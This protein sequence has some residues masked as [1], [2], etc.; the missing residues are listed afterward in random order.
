ML[1]DGKK[2]IWK[3]TYD[4][5]PLQQPG[6]QYVALAKE[7]FGEGAE[8][9]AFRFFEVASDSKTILGQPM[10][11]KSSRFYTNDCFVQTFCSTQQL[12]RRLAREFN[13]KLNETYRVDTKTPRISFLD[14]SIYEIDVGDG[15]MSVLVEEKLDHMKWTK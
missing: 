15:P 8:R 13:E 4:P 10:V 1:V 5:V 6:T 7:P 12:S 2:W 11:A 14:C 9:F 3:K